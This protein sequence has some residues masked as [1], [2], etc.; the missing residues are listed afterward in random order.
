MER[1]FTNFVTQSQYS[2]T[3]RNFRSTGTTATG[4]SGG[5]PATNATHATNAA[6]QNMIAYMQ[7]S[8]FAAALQLL[9]ST[10]AIQ[11]GSA[12]AGT[13]AIPAASAAVATA[14]SSSTKASR[15]FPALTTAL[16][17]N[18]ATYDIPFQFY[19]AYKELIYIPFNHLTDDA[20][21]KYNFK[22]PQT[23]R[24]FLDTGIAGPESYNLEDNGESQ[25]SIPEFDQAVIH[26]L[27]IVETSHPNEPARAANFATH[28]QFIQKYPH[29]IALHPA[30]MRYDI[31]KRKQYYSSG[32]DPAKV[33]QRV[34]DSFINELHIEMEVKKCFTS[35]NHHDNPATHSHSGLSRTA[36]TTT[37]THPAP[38]NSDTKSRGNCILC[39]GSGHM[40]NNCTATVQVDGRKIFGVRGS[41]GVV[42]HPQSGTPFCFKW[43]GSGKDTCS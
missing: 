15:T 12:I 18:G 39:F 22:P 28:Y 16:V 25:M 13:T 21:E 40:A 7:T 37:T 41:D 38:Y 20:I 6:A 35:F 9:A 2:H 34:L 24:K 19:D 5:V 14:T 31:W 4:I 17:Y 1:F 26:W 8:Q 11:P 10:G 32:D 33:H 43:N 30:L 3:I 29:R 36:V 23:T 42:R 27:K